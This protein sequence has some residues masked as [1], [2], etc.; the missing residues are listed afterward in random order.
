MRS[1]NLLAL[2]ALGSVLLTVSPK[3]SA[4]DV[5]ELEWRPWDEWDRVTKSYVP[6]DGAVER[7]SEVRMA[8]ATL[9]PSLPPFLFVHRTSSYFCGS[10]GCSLDVLMLTESGEYQLI[11]SWLA[12]DVKLRTDTTVNGWVPIVLGGN[13]WIYESGEYVLP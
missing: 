10:G 7:R 4:Q 13:T 6:I 11:I 2:A 3:V 5:T 8:K 1:K 12:D 9:S